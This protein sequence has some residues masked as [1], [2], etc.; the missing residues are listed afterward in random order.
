MKHFAPD[1]VKQD[2]F[3]DLPS[4][5]AG[6]HEEAQAVEAGGDAEM[7]E[8]VGKLGETIPN[9]TFHFRLSQVVAK[10]STVPTEQGTKPP[11]PNKYSSGED[12][13]AQ[14]W[15]MVEFV[16]QQEPHTGKRFAEFVGWVSANLR[17]KAAGGDAAAKQQLKNRLVRAKAIMEAAGYKPTG[18]FDLERDFFS[19]NPEV[20][21]Q[22]GQGKNKQS[23]EEQ[24]RA[25]KYFALNRPA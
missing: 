23:G 14:P 8:G 7:F 9:G 1:A 11:V 3:D 17:K 18:A 13:D 16:C 15:F 10:G 25:L 12:M 4:A 21:I 6:G 2:E 22:V 19:T 5:P 24:N 20:R